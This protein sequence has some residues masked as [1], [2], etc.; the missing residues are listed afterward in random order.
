MSTPKASQKLFTLLLQRPWLLIAMALI[1]FFGAASGLPRVVKDTRGDAFLDPHNPALLYRDKVKEQFGLNDPVAIA[2]KGNIYTPEVLHLIADLTDAVMAVKNVNEEKVFSIATEKDMRGDDGA[3]TVE[4]FLSP[5]PETV[6]QAESV[7]TAISHFPLYNGSIVAKTGDVALII[8]EIHDQNISSATYQE[9]NAIVQQQVAAFNLSSAEKV[10]GY[11]AGEAAI[12]GYLGEYIDNDMKILNPLAGLIIFTVMVIC[13]WKLTTGLFALMMIA[14]TVLS[15][16]GIMA[17]CGVPFYVITNALPVILIGIAVADTIHILSCYFEMQTKQNATGAP[18]VAETMAEMWRPVTLTSLTTVAGF[19]GLYIASDM[20]PFK[21]FG[22]FA[23]VG[24]TLAWVYSMTLLP[25]VLTLTKLHT[26][27]NFARNYANEGSRR[28]DL[29]TRFIDRVG[30]WSVDHKSLVTVIGAVVICA[31]AFSAS[32]VMVDEDRIDTFNP[33]EDIY[34][35]DKVIN[36]YTNGANNLDIIIESNEEEGLFDPQRL[37]KME[38]LQ[39]YA[40]S[41]ADVTSATSIVD[42]LKQLNMSLNNGNPEYYV[43]PR[44]RDTVAQYF[45]TYSASGGSDDFEE[46]VDYAYQTANLRL[47]LHTGAYQRNREIV[48]SLQ[49]YV[50]TEFNSDDLRATLT[51]RVTVD[52]F[53]IRELG[54]G[55]VKGL[56]VALVLV[57]IMAIAVFRSVLAGILTIIPVATSLLFVYTTMVLLDIPL[58]IGS[59]MFA[60]I[61]IGLGVDFSIHTVDRIKAVIGQSTPEDETTYADLVK[62]IFPNTGRALLFNFLALAAGFGVLTVSNVVPLNEFG[63]IVV[64]AVTGSFLCSMTLLP[65]LALLTKPAFFFRGITDISPAKATAVPVILLCAG[66]LTINDADASASNISADDIMHNVV[67]V[68]EGEH[69]VRNLKMT[70]VNK[71]G[72]ERVRETRIFRITDDSEKRTLVIYEAPSN[73]EGTAF[74]TYDYQKSEADDDQW[75]YL[76]ATRKARRISASNRGDYFLGTDFTYEDIK[77]EGKLELSDYTFERLPDT[78]AEGKTYFTIKATPRNK[79]IAD[80]LGYGEYSFTVDPDNWIIIEGNYLDT[81]GRKLKT[82][83][84]QRVKEINGIWSRETLLV[85]NHQTG[86]STL[87]EFSDIDYQTPIAADV[88][89]VRTLGQ[90]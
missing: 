18:L 17:Y 48:E 74:L 7:R 84:L 9:I 54:G 66:T 90:R 30:N 43:L 63:L 4:E 10:S 60:S 36:G 20:P 15:T 12:A 61:A 53:W 34:K 31:G 14:T 56:I 89:D 55:H 8:A 32:H 50:D 2:I 69:V 40:L 42:Y 41:F 25:A 37:R 77:N 29:F 67:A 28:Q 78:T 38:A 88:F 65:A 72:K 52:Y 1:L 73:V 46:E 64:V 76:P 23:A 80:E 86:H 62:Q 81:K 70:L 26:S 3:L 21:F 44:D 13:F 83:H 33:K 45:L 24:V 85:E 22:L 27:A 82:V 57:L 6:A 51:G 5:F 58:G 75:L 11:V 87:F 68:N 39:T 35:A 79:D 19:I 71:H 49:K 47:T 59:S 16:L